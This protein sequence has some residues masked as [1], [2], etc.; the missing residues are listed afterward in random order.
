MN[1]ILRRCGLWTFCLFFLAPLFGRTSKQHLVYY[2]PTM[3]SGDADLIANTFDMIV[4]PF[5][6]KS[7]L[8]QIKSSNVNFE[9]Y[10][11]Q[12][13]RGIE[14]SSPYFPDAEQ[15]EAWFI[16]DSQGHRLINDVWGWYLIDVSN[17]AWRSYI[18]LKTAARLSD[19][20][21]LDGLYSDDTSLTLQKNGWHTL[22]KSE[23]TTVL[24][25]NTVQTTWPVFIQDIYGVDIK[26]SLNPDGSGT[27]YFTGGHYTV[28]GKI[29]TLGTPLAAGTA[30]YV[31]YR[32]KDDSVMFA[33]QAK[34]DSWPGGM[35]QI[36]QDI[37]SAV[38]GKKILANVGLAYDFF[39]YVD[40]IMNEHF[41]NF[42]SFSYWRNSIEQLA[43][44]MD[45]GKI[46]LANQNT[47]ASPSVASK[48]LFVFCSYL[49]GMGNKSY[50]YSH[51]KLSYTTISH[52]PLWDVDL[53]QPTADFSVITAEDPAL[54]PHNTMNLLT[55]ASFE[56]DVLPWRS[57]T[58][59]TAPIVT[60][61]TTQARTGQASLKL[62]TTTD[63]HTGG[64]YQ[65]IDVKPQTTYTATV[66]T[67]MSGFSRITPPS[68]NVGVDD[69]NGR[70][71][72]ASESFFRHAD[73]WNPITVVFRTQNN[74]AKATIYAAAIPSDI[75]GT[76][77]IDDVQVSEGISVFYRPFEKGRVYVNATNHS[78]R[79]RL[80]R[81]MKTLDNRV[82]SEETIPPQEG[83]I[84]FSDTSHAIS[85]S[86]GGIDIAPFKNYFTPGKD[87][88]IEAIF[89]T[90]DSGTANV[91]VYNRFGDK[92]T[93]LPVENFG[94]GL[95]RVTW[96]GKNDSGVKLPAGVYLFL[97]EEGSSKVIKKV[98][99]LK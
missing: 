49:L 64:T 2:T 26:I 23:A 40:G 90:T 92:M 67:K 82:V 98:V 14:P 1:M 34:I 7:Q 35:T 19:F 54:P 3:T 55:N 13:L 60:R 42:L 95:Q 47:T 91:N 68:I 50:F 84:L 66:W 43:T 79:V 22:I 61:D 96:D 51:D 48:P 24:S 75:A 31:T 69:I 33:P 12:Y 52:D 5:Q 73:T 4:M 83:L 93:S 25:G 11:Y 76:L 30:V 70:I 85:S 20:S 6:N 15:N 81:P 8:A 56:S 86:S 80:E 53:G 36:L 21:S 58:G 99:I 97:F 63:G 72:N 62:Q 77:W 78:A 46:Y 9:A 41:A 17:P 29:I 38:P 88:P 39:P 28:G 57:T 71:V 18:A 59:G 65:I 32:G 10:G 89:S 27:N 45:L 94:G 37:R 74:N 16:H 44:A 87:A